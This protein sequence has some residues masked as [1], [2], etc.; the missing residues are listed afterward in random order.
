MPEAP[1]ISLPEPAVRRFRKGIQEFNSGRFFECH[2][3]LE[4]VWRGVRGPARDFFQGL[5][6][7][8]VGFHHL[9]ARNLKGGRSQLEKG[10]GRLRSYPSPCMG[11]DLDALRRG[12]AVW[13]EWVRS[14][15]ETGGHAPP[16]PEIRF[17][18]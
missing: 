5:I 15:G 10:L 4:E 9:G 11:I 1:D 2:E 17:V 6:Q 7:V 16:L 8:A 14:V 18:P 3:T 13:L 12:A